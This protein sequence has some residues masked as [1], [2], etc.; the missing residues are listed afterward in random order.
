MTA[1]VSTNVRL[2]PAQL[3]RLKR[4]AADRGISLSTVFREMIGEYIGRISP[5]NDKAWM[6]DPF[7]RIGRRP[8]RSGLSRVSEDHDRYLYPPKR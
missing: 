6:A 8:G 7:F 4:V 3:S 5:L 2:D 1:R